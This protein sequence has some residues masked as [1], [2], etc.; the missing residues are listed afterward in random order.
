MLISMDLVQV[1][2]KLDKSKFVI[3]LSWNPISY[4]LCDAGSLRQKLL[5]WSNP[6]LEWWGVGEGGEIMMMLLAKENTSWRGGVNIGQTSSRWNPVWEQQL[7]I[8][9]I[10]DLC[11]LWIE[12]CVVY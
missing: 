7:I 4:A 3:K 6:G 12:K 5:H 9:P 2:E 1:K 10:H 11:P 8:S